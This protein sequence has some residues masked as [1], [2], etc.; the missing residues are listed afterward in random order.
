MAG[1]DKTKLMDPLP[2]VVTALEELSEVLTGG[3]YVSDNFW[4]AADQTA[5]GNYIKGLAIGANLKTTLQQVT[6]KVPAVKTAMND[7]SSAIQKFIDQVNQKASSVTNDVIGP[8]AHLNTPHPAGN[9]NAADFGFF[10]ALLGIGTAAGVDLAA[11]Q[12]AL[13]T[14]VGVATDAVSYSYFVVLATETLAL[15]TK[16]MS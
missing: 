2:K 4:T 11:V 16:A 15:L 13:N 9:Y 5:A 8:V 12:S 3:S 6:S 7:A 10:P 14:V 1:A